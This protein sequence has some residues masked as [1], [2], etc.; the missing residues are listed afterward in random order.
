MTV[1]KGIVTE[2]RIAAF[3][4]HLYTAMLRA[5]YSKAKLGKPDFATLAAQ[6]FD[7]SAEFQKIGELRGEIVT[8]YLP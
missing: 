7:A 2:S 5:R 1:K 6:A 8:E 3:A 4:A